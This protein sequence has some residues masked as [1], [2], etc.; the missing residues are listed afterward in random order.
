[1]ATH[2]HSF[3][4][5]GFLI[6]Y[7]IQ[8]QK[9]QPKAKAK[10]EFHSYI[11]DLIKQAIKSIDNESSSE[12]EIGVRISI[13]QHSGFFRDTPEISPPRNIIAFRRASI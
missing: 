9:S 11:N 5:S 10:V 2:T 8:A 1:M 4:K 13:N 6:S 3:I 12:P 7:L